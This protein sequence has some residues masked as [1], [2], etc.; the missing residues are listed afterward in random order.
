MSEVSINLINAAPN[1][2]SL[3]TQDNSTRTVS[4]V[5]IPVPNHCPKVFF[6]AAKGSPD[7]V[8]LNPAQLLDYYGDDTFDVNKPYYNH[9]T[10]L[11][12]V[13]TANRN[14]CVTQRIVPSDSVTANMVIYLDVLPTTVNIYQRN[15]DGSLV[16]DT[17]GAPISTGTTDGY[18]V[19]WVKQYYTTENDVIE[20]INLATQKTGTM[21]DPSTGATSTLYPIFD[22]TANSPGTFGNMVAFR[23]WAAN[24]KDPIDPSVLTTNRVFP[25]FF[26]MYNTK[27][28]TK[29]PKLITNLLGASYTNISLNKIPPLGLQSIYNIMDSYNNTENPN[30]PFKINDINTFNVYRESIDTLSAMFMTAELPH[31]VQGWDFTP[32]SIV[33]DDKYMFNFITGANFSG[34]PY[35]SYQFVDDVDSFRFSKLTNIFA[36]GG[37]DGT[38]SSVDF[39]NAVSSIMSDYLDPDSRVQDL[40]LSPETVIYDSGFGLNTKLKLCQFIGLRKNTNVILST[41]VANENNIPNDNALDISIAALL[42]SR[43]NLFP[44][45]D[46]FG[47]PVVRGLVIG[48]SMILNDSLYTARLPMTFEIADKMSAYMGAGN[49]VWNST[50]NPEGE[51]GSIVK[52]GKSIKPEF[53][54][55]TSR[56][57]NWFLGLNWVQAYDLKSYYIPAYKTIH[58]NSTSVLNSL[59]TSFAIATI[60][61]IVNQMWRGMEGI[62][63]LSAS[64]F[65]KKIINYMVEHTKGI[66]DNRFYLVFIPEMTQLDEERGY[67]ITLAVQIGANNMKTVLTTY[68]QAYRMSDLILLNNQ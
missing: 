60:N 14:S 61:T 44:E 2:Y 28:S 40:A 65:K 11:L 39:D 33:D 3:G 67:S 30:L 24:Y 62:S 7:P 63:Y 58:I 52:T 10:A 34:I 68:T 12:N 55:A 56:Y 51:P 5:N 6:Y 27:D 29:S 21:T 26:S 35:T 23:L 41:Y 32:S 45:S 43:L 48:Q 31:A 4:Y 8:F 19:K 20:K 53:L 13:F 22:A 17:N 16:Y 46:Y 25:Y 49:G 54:S 1:V 38:M 9:A 15:A 37:N 64:Q 57:S 47:T 18:K 50:Y 66:F 59:I 36:N 42:K